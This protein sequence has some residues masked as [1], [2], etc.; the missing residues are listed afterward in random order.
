LNY[1]N[2]ATLT[3]K[4]KVSLEEQRK[5]NLPVRKTEAQEDGVAVP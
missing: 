2:V 5:E 3:A 4:N 1:C